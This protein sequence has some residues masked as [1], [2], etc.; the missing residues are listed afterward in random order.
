MNTEYR[1]TAESFGDTIPQNWEE[2][3]AYLN[4]RIDEMDLDSLPE[5]EQRDAV[6]ALWES[7]WAGELPEAPAAVTEG[8]EED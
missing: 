3:A 7:Y 8:E 2:I 6:D 1:I 5:R 4:A